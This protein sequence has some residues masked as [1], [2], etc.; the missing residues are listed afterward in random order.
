MTS[1]LDLA[2]STKNLQAFGSMKDR[3]ALSSVYEPQVVGFC[4]SIESIVLVSDMPGGWQLP[5][6]CTIDYCLHLYSPHRGACIQS[7]LLMFVSLLFF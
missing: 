2:Q 7:A 3:P 5:P 4:G 1:S 6:E